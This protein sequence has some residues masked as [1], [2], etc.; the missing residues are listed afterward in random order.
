MHLDAYVYMQGGL[1]KTIC[2]FY[3]KDATNAERVRAKVLRSNVRPHAGDPNV[4]KGGRP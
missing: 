4:V 3:G 1:E 2:M